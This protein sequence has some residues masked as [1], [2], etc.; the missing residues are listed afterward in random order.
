VLHKLGLTQIVSFLVV[1]SNYSGSNPRFDMCIT[2]LRL[3]ILSVVDDV[4]VDT[5]SSTARRLLIDFMN[6]KIKSIQSFRDVYRGRMYVRVFIGVS[7]HICMNICIC[8]V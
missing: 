3:I 4:P 1:K 5:S 8:T 2:Y 7:A 6:I